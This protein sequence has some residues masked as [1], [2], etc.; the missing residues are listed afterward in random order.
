MLP[1]VVLLGLDLGLPS[2]GG[3]SWVSS[4]ESAPAR[5]ALH[6]LTIANIAPLGAVGLRRLLDVARGLRLLAARQSAALLTVLALAA[7]VAQIEDAHRLVAQ[8][9]VAGTRAWT[10]AALDRL[11]DQSMILTHSG[12]VGRRLLAAQRQGERPDVLV[13]PLEH[14]AREREVARW[15]AL[16]P[17]LK[18]LIVNLSLGHTPTE[19]ALALLSDARSVFVEPAPPWEKRLLV[20]LEPTLPLARFSPAPLA[21]SD[22]LL[23]L[24]ERTS[25]LVQILEATQLGLHPDLATQSVLTAGLERTRA[26]LESIGDR[27]T[28]KALS[29]AVPPQLVRPAPRLP[30]GS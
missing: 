17:A 3:S 21:S 18:P 9:E 11:P 27:R 6:L 7:A 14:L 26:M 8:T 30:A 20:H 4:L 12:S 22:R 10:S 29:D 24:A 15:L 5:V 13:V 23:G 16:E 19:N 28:A 25:G 1:A 2:S